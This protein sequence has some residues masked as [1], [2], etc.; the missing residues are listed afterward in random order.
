MNV[1]PDVILRGI[2]VAAVLAVLWLYQRQ[3]VYALL[4]TVV[5]LVLGVVGSELNSVTEEMVRRI[6]GEVYDNYL[7]V[8]LVWIGKERFQALAWL[9]W[10][11]FVEWWNANPEAV[12]VAQKLRPRPQ[13][14]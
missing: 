4:E 5:K 11:K 10:Q 13:L 7:P 3:R 1:T 9:T 14:L 6:A 12:A 8:W 2:A